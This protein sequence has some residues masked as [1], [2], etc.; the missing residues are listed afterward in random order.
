MEIRSKIWLEI[1]G[2]PVLGGGR[3]SL[4]QGIAQCGSINRASKQLHISYRKALSYIQT[5]EQRLGVKLVDR[6]AGG[7]HGGG[8]TLTRNA[9]EYL[10]KYEK[11]EH[12]INKMLDR[13]YE[14]VFGNK[15]RR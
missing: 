1:N 3:C 15:K 4:L 10:K 14:E 7:R 9:K 13:R 6:R 5:M 12:G 11:L 8:A 2:E